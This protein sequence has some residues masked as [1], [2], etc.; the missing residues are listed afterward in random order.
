MH[1]LPIRSFQLTSKSWEGL[2]SEIQ[3]QDVLNWGGKAEIVYLKW[4]TRSREGQ[5][6]ASMVMEFDSPVVANQAIDQ[7][8]YWNSE[9]HSVVLFY[10]DG[11]VKL[12]HK[13]RNQACSITLPTQKLHTRSLRRRVSEL[14]VPVLAWRHDLD[15]VR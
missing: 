1:G 11:R 4:L 2:V 10:R 3:R 6:E 15:Q 8:L 9:A 13:C 14:G 5:R 7:G 12:C